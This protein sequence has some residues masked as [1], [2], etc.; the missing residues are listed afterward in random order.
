MTNEEK[1]KSMST[2]EFVDWLMDL[3]DWNQ[4]ECWECPAQKYCNSDDMSGNCCR[5]ALMG[6]LK[7]EAEE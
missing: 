6:W 4:V 2:E 5:D 3:V 1:I 7:E